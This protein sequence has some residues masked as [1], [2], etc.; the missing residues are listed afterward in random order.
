MRSQLVYDLPTR[1]FHWLFAAL[2]VT[3]FIIAKNVDSESPAFANHMLFGMTLSFIVILRVIWGLVGSQYARFSS[4]ALH[5]AKLIQYFTDMLSGQSKRSA[6]H[7]PASS[8]V[9]VVMMIL[10]LSLGISGYLMSTGLNEELEDIHE[11]LA[12]SFVI[13]AILHVAGV[14]MHTVQHKDPIALSMIDGKKQD[15]VGTKSL[16]TSHP[17]VAVLFL[18]LVTAFGMNLWKNYDSQSGTLNLFGTTLQL[19]DSDGN[20]AGEGNENGEDDDGKENGDDD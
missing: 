19:G 17:L 18:V 15:I 12:N 2:F 5:P 9:A 4:F 1:L 3:A 6:G 16:T 20:E 8:W 7:N 13:V 10:A 14:L 11:I